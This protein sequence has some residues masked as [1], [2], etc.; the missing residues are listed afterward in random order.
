MRLLAPGSPLVV[1]CEYS[2]P[3][4]EC[5]SFLH[6]EELAI[7]LLL[8]ETTLREYQTLPGQMHPLMKGSATGGFVLYGTF[9]GSST[10]H[11]TLLAMKMKEP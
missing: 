9:V 1:Y 4:I 7:R 5:Y 11:A 8:V 3:L 2:E 6:Q 10:L